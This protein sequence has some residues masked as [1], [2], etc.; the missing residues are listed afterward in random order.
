MR[1]LWL[2]NVNDLPVTGRTECAK[3]NQ[4]SPPECE[5]ASQSVASIP[6]AGRP[7][8]HRFDVTSNAHA[9]AHDA[10]RRP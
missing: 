9:R 4:Q 1:V 10:L 8:R 2:S 6:I 7:S 3:C 5:C